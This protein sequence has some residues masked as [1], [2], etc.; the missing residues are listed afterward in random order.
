MAHWILRSVIARIS[1]VILTNVLV[2]LFVVLKGYKK[3][4]RC[5]HRVMI[6]VRHQSYLI[7]FAAAFH[8]SILLV[9]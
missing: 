4:R 1:F 8:K 6:I 2:F 3:V 5:N 9:S 7:L